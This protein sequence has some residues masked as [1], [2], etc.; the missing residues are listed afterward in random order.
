MADR[1]VTSIQAR[2][3]ETG[4]RIVRYARFIIFELFAV[5]ATG[6]MVRTSSRRFNRHTHDRVFRPT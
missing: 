5:T 4:A 6:L 2:L 3:M 1:S